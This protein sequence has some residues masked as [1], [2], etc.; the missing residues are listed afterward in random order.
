MAASAYACLPPVTHTL[1]RP[2]DYSSAN[3]AAAAAPAASFSPATR[4]LPQVEGFD[5]GL[6]RLYSRPSVTIFSAAWASL[7][8]GPTS[9]LATMHSELRKADFVRY[10]SSNGQPVQFARCTMS[11][12]AERRLYKIDVPV[13]PFKLGSVCP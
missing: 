10:G 12:T 4:R 1:T 3:T 8:T 2:Q 6:I 11:R 13:E 9:E 7:I 5:C